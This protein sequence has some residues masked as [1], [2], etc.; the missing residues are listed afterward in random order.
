MFGSRALGG[1]GLREW[2]LRLRWEWG[3]GRGVE[4]MGGLSTCKVVGGGGLLEEGK[5]KLRT[6]K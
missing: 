1:G 6:R 2:V 5:R 3:G 4:G